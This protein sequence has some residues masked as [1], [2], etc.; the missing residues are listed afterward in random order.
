VVF[1]LAQE[2]IYLIMSRV[3]FMSDPS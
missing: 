1:S 3:F 2:Q